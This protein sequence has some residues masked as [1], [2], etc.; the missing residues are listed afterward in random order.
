MAKET[1]VNI[2]NT[3]Y[4]PPEN[5][6]YDNTNDENDFFNHIFGKQQKVQQNEV[7]LYLK[8]SQAKP[9]QDILLW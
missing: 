6:D 7:D 2:Y 1:V 8:A 5:L 9:K 4:G 3:N